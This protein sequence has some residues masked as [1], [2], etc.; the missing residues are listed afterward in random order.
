MLTIDDYSISLLGVS[1]WQPMLW[2]YGIVFCTLLIIAITFLA[3]K[4]ILRHS[5]SRLLQG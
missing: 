4:R 3:A 5:I 1:M 2:L